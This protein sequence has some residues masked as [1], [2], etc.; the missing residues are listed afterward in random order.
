MPGSETLAGLS[1]FTIGSPVVPGEL[2]A[3]FVAGDK[4]EPPRFAPRPTVC[5]AVRA[6]GRTKS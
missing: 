5:E 3:R 6:I 1:F 4:D 2:A